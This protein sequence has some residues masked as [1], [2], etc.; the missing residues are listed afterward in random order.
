M[1]LFENKNVN[2]LFL[3]SH[4]KSKMRRMN[5]CHNMYHNTCLNILSIILGVGSVISLFTLGSIYAKDQTQ[6]GILVGIIV[7]AVIFVGSIVYCVIGSCVTRN[8]LYC[9]ESLV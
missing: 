8:W 9:G 6:I 1:N 7:S 5:Y 2:I 4:R 3:V